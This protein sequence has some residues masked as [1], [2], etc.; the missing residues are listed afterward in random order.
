MGNKS[1]GIKTPMNFLKTKQWKKLFEKNNLK[2]IYAN[3]DYHQ[4]KKDIIKHILI[5]LKV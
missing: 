3:Y 2:V 5:K 1:Y 4:K